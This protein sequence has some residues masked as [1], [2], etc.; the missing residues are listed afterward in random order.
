MDPD[1]TGSASIRHLTVLIT[2]LEH[3]T[4]VTAVVEY[5]QGGDEV[6][7]GISPL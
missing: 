3:D 4:H 1:V 5:L 2:A 7:G 6:C